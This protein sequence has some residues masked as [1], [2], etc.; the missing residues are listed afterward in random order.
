LPSFGWIKDPEDRR[1]LL[2]R[3][4]FKAVAIP[5]EVDLS[6]NAGDVG[7]QGP[8]G[9]CV[10]WGHKALKDWH[11]KTQGDFPKGG[12]SARC[13][14]NGARALEN[15]LGEEGAYLRD[16]LKFLQTFGTCTNTRWP[17]K[18]G[19]DS[20]KDPRIV[21]HVDDMKNWKIT[22]YTRIDRFDGIPQALAAGRPVVAGINWPS[23]WI[24]IT[25][26]EDL[27]RSNGDYVGGHCIPFFKY[28]NLT[29]RLGFMNSWGKLWAKWGWATC[30][31]DDI[32]MQM[33]S[34]DFWWTTD[35]VVPN[36]EPPVP[37]TPQPNICKYLIP[38]RDSLNIALKQLGC[39]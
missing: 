30:S 19:V 6:K 14:Y 39:S 27:P 37:P 16:A 17:Y 33:N 7:D 22:L 13:I 24:S 25:V 18:A 35:L 8:E 21:I 20:D 34:C 1:D 5:D 15:R 28:N 11:E 4:I 10:G 32:E 9:S 23:N 36:P 12:L 26:I 2:F 38:I 31:Y 3:R 29:Q